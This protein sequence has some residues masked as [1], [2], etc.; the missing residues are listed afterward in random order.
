MSAVDSE[1]ERIAAV[2]HDVIEDSAYTAAD[3]REEGFSD[4]VLQALEALTRQQGE[5][6]L[7]FVRRAGANPL[8]KRVKL[9]DL[10]D[11]MDLSRIPHPTE[12]D[13]K[14]YLKYRQAFEALQAGEKQPTAA[15]GREQVDAR[16]RE[17]APGR[18]VLRKVRD[19]DGTRHLQA[20]L[21]RDGD[22]L[23]E[24]QDLGAGVE[25]A[26]G[27]YEYEWAWTIRAPDVPLLLGALGAT[28]DVLSA[29]REQFSEDRAARLMDFLDSHNIPYERWSRMGE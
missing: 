21:T 2:L 29:L 5:D 3:L 7:T 27:V 1:E 14:R 4:T 28:S 23:I 20:S 11:N 8:A 9:A 17:T 18:V 13:F 25:R 24:G 15:Q 26:L 22:V 6:Y 12:E 19:A 16:D 10:I